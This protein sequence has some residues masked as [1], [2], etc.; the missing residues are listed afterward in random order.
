MVRIIDKIHARR[1]ELRFERERALAAAAQLRQQ[2]EAAA[3]AALPSHLRNRPRRP[4]PASSPNADDAAANGEQE[5]LAI[6]PGFYYSL[7]FF[8]PKTEPGLDNLLARIDRMSRRL[9]PLFVSVTWGANGSTLP[10]TLAVASHAQRFACVDVLLHLSCTGL[11]KER[12]GQV[13]GMARSAGIRNILAL[14]GDPPAGR[15][16]WRDGE[17]SGGEC[18]RAVDLVRLIRQLH[19][20][21]FGIGVAGHPE[22][23]PSSAKGEEGRATELIHLKEKIDAGADFIITQFFYDV[24]V[25]LDYV[26]RCRACGIT[27]PIIPG[28]MPVQSYSSLV[29]MTQ[30]CGISVPRSVIERLETVRHDDEAVKKIGCEIAAEMCRRIL[31][32]SQSGDG[33]IDESLHVDGFHFY[34]LNLERSTTRILA[35]MGVLDIPGDSS[36]YGSGSMREKQAGKNK[37]VDFVPEAANDAVT[38]REGRERQ[39]SISERARSTG[40]RVLPWKPSAME[41]RSREDVRPINWSNRPKSYVMRTDDWDEYPNGRWG[42]STSPAFGELS[43]LSHFYSFSLGSDDDRRAMLGNCPLE[44][45]DVFEVFARY[46]EGTVPHIPWCETPL[47]PESFL[48]QSQLA[49]LNRYGLLTVNSQPPVDGA[50]SDHPA[51]GWGGKGGMVYQKAYVECFVS[52]DKANRLT[53]MVTDH[54]NMNLYAVNYSG[55]ELRVGVGEGGVTAL[56]WGVFPNRE[57]LQPTIFDPDTFLVWAEEAFSLWSSMWLNLYD[58]ESDSYE[59]IEKIRDTYYLVAIIDNDFASGGKDG[60]TFRLLDVLLEIGRGPS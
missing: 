45:S 59:L 52:P 22:G 7:E 18:D 9:D 38:G 3:K 42:D 46:V 13:L 50:S 35:D 2:S 40:R 44:E 43:E 4:A 47:H 16:A 21:H 60:S 11:T 27:C 41:N 37:I 56:T 49:R 57:I 53:R 30:F 32:S 15:R 33:D 10:R 55:Q 58:F 26:K 29:K 39:G 54:P 36:S 28:I 5:S 17:V 6:Q 12:I 20:D 19:G 31:A 14:R 48:V 51:F 25:F 23:H 1:K 24:D 8:P 34:T